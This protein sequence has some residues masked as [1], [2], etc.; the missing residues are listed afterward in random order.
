MPSI[1]TNA[2]D[3][4]TVAPSGGETIVVS[5]GFDASAGAGDP[6][7]TASTA[8]VAA[9]TFQA[10]RRVARRAARSDFAI[11]PPPSCPLAGRYNRRPPTC[12]GSGAGWRYRAA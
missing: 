11:A 12:R 5:G 8:A 7:T 2:L 4:G 9:S 6:K 3:R 1:V 10:E